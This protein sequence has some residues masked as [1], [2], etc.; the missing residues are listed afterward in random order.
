MKNTKITKVERFE[1]IREMVKDNEE[2]VAF[3]NAEIARLQARAGKV[4]EKRNEKNAEKADEYKVAIIKTL[5]DASRA[6]T[7]AELVAGV[8]IEGA[9]PGRVA[10]YAGKLVNAEAIERDKAKVGDRKV[11][12]YKLA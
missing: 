8:G 7:L 11:T 3:L 6:I 4:A 5:E 2:Y 10:Y 12:V 9:T 1:A